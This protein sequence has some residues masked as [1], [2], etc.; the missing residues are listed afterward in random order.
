MT[1]TPFF[2][3]AQRSINAM[4]ENACGTSCYSQDAR[5]I[6]RNKLLSM[7][8]S[9]SIK[10]TKKKQLLRTLADS[11]NTDVWCFL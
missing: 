8:R 5:S 4:V 11:L 1:C 9:P 10:S 2:T 3:K 7:A 6:A